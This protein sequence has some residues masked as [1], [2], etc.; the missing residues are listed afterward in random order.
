MNKASDILK[1]N[2]FK[3]HFEQRGQRVPSSHVQ[4]LMGSRIKTL[5]QI[6]ERLGGN[7]FDKT[8]DQSMMQ[9]VMKFK[10]WVSNTVYSTNP[11]TKKELRTLS[12]SL[13]FE[14]NGQ[15]SIFK[16]TW[17]L[18]KAL[19]LFEKNWRSSYIPGLLDCYFSNWEVRKERAFG[20][21]AELIFEKISNYEGTRKLY[22]DLK[23]T[24]KYFDRQKGDVE[25]GATM[26][27]KNVPL[28]DL[29]KFLN[30][31]KD[32]ISYPYFL[33]VIAGFVERSKNRL[34]QHLHEIEMVLNE[35]SSNTPG[36]KANKIIVG[37]L[38]CYAEHANVDLQDQIKDVAFNLVGDPESS[39][40][41]RFPG[42]TPTDAETLLRAKTILNEW[43]TRQFITVFFEKCI[44]NDRRKRFWLK[45]S[46][47][48]TRF[49]VF[50]PRSVKNMLVKDERI[51]K[52]V[53]ERFQVVRGGSTV[54]AFMFSLGHH[55][56]IEFSDKGYAFYAYKQSN[57]HAPEFDIKQLMSVDSFR[58]G[59]MPPLVRKDGHYLYSY[60]E[61]GR[62]GHGDHTLKWEDVFYKWIEKI[63]GI[64]V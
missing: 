33:G 39:H 32:W 36:T 10:A 28:S 4:H 26:A 44:N 47:E 64:D 58:R 53:G 34:G 63:V 29:T 45:Y 38:V 48:I 16:S 41:N 3:E 9:V 24:L 21:L 50:G 46:K 56:M 7:S 55:R 12:Y 25:L 13:D 30:V 31:P 1:F 59:S 57:P 5:E 27:L 18:E 6:S 14:V 60:S 61:E 35:H 52:Y 20:L 8:S 23:T 42:V 62:L 49:K 37:R 17:E 51:S 15:M 19:D 40:W 43:I 22:H 2:F 54:S 11:F